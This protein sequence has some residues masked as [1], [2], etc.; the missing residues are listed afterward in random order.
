MGSLCIIFYESTWIYNYMQIKSLS[1]KIREISEN[2]EELKYKCARSWRGSVVK[3]RKLGAKMIANSDHR[4]GLMLFK[5][6]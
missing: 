1:N 3:I 5:L 2:C 4:W 6:I